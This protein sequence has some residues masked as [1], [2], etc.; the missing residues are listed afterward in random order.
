MGPTYTSWKDG[1]SVL[2]SWGLP[3][4]VEGAGLLLL[5]EGVSGDDSCNISGMSEVLTARTSIHILTESRSVNTIR[6]NIKK[7][8]IQIAFFT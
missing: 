4:T 1:W 6:I 8:S 7:K 3:V 5:A 2:L